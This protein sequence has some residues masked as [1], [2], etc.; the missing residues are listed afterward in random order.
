MSIAAVETNDIKDARVYAENILETIREPLIVLDEELRVVSANKSFYRTFHVSNAETV[1]NVIYEL[2]NRQWNI[3]RLKDALET[4]IPHNSVFENLEVEY[5]FPEIGEKIMLLNGRRINQEGVRKHLI[6]LAIEDIT[7]R[8][9]AENALK[10]SDEKYVNLMDNINSIILQISPEGKITFINRFAEK[11]FGY[12]KDDIINQSI[13]GTLLPEKDPAGRSNAAMVKDLIRN[14]ENYYFQQTMGVRKGGGQVWFQWSAKGVRDEQGNVN[15][16]LVDGNDI[17]GLKQGLEQGNLAKNIIATIP[18]PSL[19]LNEQL[20]VVSANPSFY[21]VFQVTSQETENRYVYELGNKQWNIPALRDAL[22]KIIPENGEVYNFELRHDFEGIGKKVMLLNGRRIEQEQPREALIFL[23]IRDITEQKQREEEVRRFNI[24]LHDRNKELDAF[25]YSI[26]HDLRSH[27]RA[28]DGFSQIL[29]D[30]YS[31]A[32]DAEGRRLLGIVRDNTKRMSQLISDLLKLS[33]T[34]RMDVQ[35][36]DINMTAIVNYLLKQVT[37]DI[38]ERKI[39]SSVHALPSAQG[40]LPMISQVWTNLI[41]NAVKFT[42]NRDV[43]R[44]EIGGKTE[45]GEHVYYV[46]D[47]GAGFDNLYADKLFG[48]FQRLHSEEDFPGTGVGL[49]IVK[50]II[51]RHGGRAWAE[52]KLGEGAIFYFT[53]PVSPK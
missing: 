16:I 44:I 39:E 2:G 30:D 45:G 41:A 38:G 40:D 33:R 6:L 43:A 15:G 28:I 32:L 7:D 37:S 23:S 34:T 11:I 19:I 27:L 21:S 13:V 3:L 47:N 36:T 53:L 51:N 20:R 22:E 14:P 25:N 31:G 50:R 10:A 4:I 8:K 48:I 42:A 24:L 26:S 29:L 9:R 1:G 49:A 17:T 52:G 5:H 46:K 35:H 18:E 12:H